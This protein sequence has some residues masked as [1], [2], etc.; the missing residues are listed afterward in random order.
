[1]DFVEK[2]DFIYIDIREGMYG[3][4]QADCIAFDCLLKLM[5]ARGYYPL[6]SN[7]G[8]WCHETLPTKSTLC[9]H[10]F[11]IKYTNT[12]H[13]H[14]LVDTLKKYCTISID[15]VGGGDYCG[16]TLD[17]NYDKKHVDI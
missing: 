10:S 9:M 13:A 3:I 12:D 7:P 2:D 17:W 15:C 16:L 8:I 4:K 6:R 14:H 5:K 11:G 1:M